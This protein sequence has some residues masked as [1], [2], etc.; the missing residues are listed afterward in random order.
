MRYRAQ[1]DPKLPR[2]ACCSLLPTV[3]AAEWEFSPSCSGQM[4]ISETLNTLFMA[5]GPEGGIEAYQHP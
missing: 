1:F 2:N 3:N 5:L 4:D